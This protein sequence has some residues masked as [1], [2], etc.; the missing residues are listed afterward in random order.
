MPSQVLSIFSNALS[1]HQQAA[2]AEEVRED[3]ANGFILDI[4]NVHGNAV[5][6]LARH[7]LVVVADGL[8]ARLTPAG[9]RLHAALNALDE[10][11]TLRR[12]AAHFEKPS[13]VVLHA[14]GL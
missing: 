13:D 9:V 6:G 3:K 8:F 11:E 7:G 5:R 2:M 12:H 14:A 4:T 1:D 10:E